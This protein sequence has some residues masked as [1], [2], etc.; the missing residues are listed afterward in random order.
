[1]PNPFTY[2]GRITNPAQFIGRG[3]ELQTI[4]SALETIH[5]GQLQHVQVVGERRIGKSSLLFH[6]TQIYRQRLTQPEKYR[7]VYVDLDDGRCH[8][9]EGLLK[10]I[11]SQLGL[12]NKPALAK[13]QEA[14]EELSREQEIYPILCLDEFEHLTKRKDQ[15]PNEVFEVWRSLASGSKL[16]FI[17]SSQTSLGQLIQQ[18]NLTS[19]FHNIFIYLELGNFTEAEARTLLARNID[20]PFTEEEIGKLFRLAGYHPAHLQ[21]AAQLLYEA[22]P[23]QTVNWTEL[24]AEYEK[25]VEQI[26]PFTPKDN[27]PPLIQKILTSL[28]INFP[29]ALGR[30]ILE[31]VKNKDASDRTAAILGWVII[32]LLI[33]ILLGIISTSALEPWLHLAPTSST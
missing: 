6:V 7:F 15:F 20:H 31:V 5:S 8:T 13:F 21:I 16:A 17:T 25:R 28:F 19:T 33:S 26:K 29:T 30:F 4:F 10:Y 14:I 3:K 23:S 32:L 11:S 18:G 9:L 27:Q 22:K 24:K 2:G 1:V 12:S